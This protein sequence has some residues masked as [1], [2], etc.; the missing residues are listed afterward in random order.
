MT[1]TATETPYEAIERLIHADDIYSVLLGMDEVTSDV[2]NDVSDEIMALIRPILERLKAA[3]NVCVMVGW[4]GTSSD[5]EESARA[6]AAAVLWHEWT[7]VPGVSTDA[8]DH[9]HLTDAVIAR[10]ADGRDK[11]RADA[12]AR[13]AAMH[14]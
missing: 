8:A 13:I 2:L 5:P 4:T 14:S 11:A 10:L 6:K 9:P 12:R 7:K 1:T 3:E